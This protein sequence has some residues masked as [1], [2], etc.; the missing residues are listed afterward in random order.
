MMSLALC[1]A[2]AF[3][4]ALGIQGGHATGA[5][6][7]NGLAV[8]MVLNIA[9]SEYARHRGH[10]SHALEAAF[11]DDVTVFHVKLVDKQARVGRVPNR[12]KG[13][14]DFKVFGLI[15]LVIAQANARSEEHTSELQSRGHLVCRLLLEKKNN[16]LCTEPRCALLRLLAASF[17][18]Q[19]DPA[20]QCRE[21]HFESHQAQI[22]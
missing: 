10:G 8:N 22:N 2:F 16:Q 15:S 18:T 17:R 3:Q 14:A 20:Q 19:E 6:T 9:S 13:A 1:L 11:G 4:P 21:W 7:G 12:N 5:R